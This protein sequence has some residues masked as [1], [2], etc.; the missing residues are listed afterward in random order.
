MAI[1]IARITNNLNY[2]FTMPGPSFIG[3]QSSNLVI[4]ANAVDLD[5]LTLTTD[6]GLWSIQPQ[7]EA[8]ERTGQVTVTG[9]IDTASFDYDGVSTIHADNNPAVRGNIRLVSGTNITLSQ[10]GQNITINSS[11]GGGGGS[12]SAPNNSIQFNNSG[13]FGG[14]SDLTWDGTDLAALNIATSSLHFDTGD[15]NIITTAGGINIFSDVGSSILLK[16]G[17]LAGIE[18]DNNVVGLGRPMFFDT[19]NTAA[20]NA[21]GNH[22]GWMIY[23][24][25]TNKPEFNNGS[26]WAAMTGGGS[27]SPAGSNTWIQYNDSGV[28]G[29]DGNFNWDK[30]GQTLSITGTAGSG[31]GFRGEAVAITSDVYISNGNLW[32]FGGPGDGNI[33]MENGGNILLN[34]TSGLD[35]ASYMTFSGGAIN[36]IVF[37]GTFFRVDAAGN[38]SNS[39]SLR[40]QAIGAPALSSAAEGSIY[41][42]SVLNK[43]MASE[44][45]GAYV[46]LVGSGGGSMVEASV[47]VNGSSTGVP[48]TT[49]FTPSVS[50]S[51]RIASYAVVTQSGATD[52][53]QAFLSWTDTSGVQSQNLSSNMDGSAGGGNLPLDP[54]GSTY[55]AEALIYAVA[56][57]PISYQIN[58]LNNGSGAGLYT[59]Y[60]TLESVSVGGG[61]GGSPSAPS[62]SVQYNNAGAFGSTAEISVLSAQ[63]GG[64]TMLVG[65]DPTTIVP[66]GIVTWLDFI[67]NNNGQSS[68][69]IV[70]TDLQIYS[71]AR[72]NDLGSTGVAQLGLNYWSGGSALTAATLTVY[73]PADWSGV[74]ITQLR[75]QADIFLCPAS[76]QVPNQSSV[77]IGDSAGQRVGDQTAILDI[78]ST[79]Q[80]FLPPRMTQAQRNIITVAANGITYVENFAPLTGATFTINGVV[81]TEGVEWTASTDNLTTATSLSAAI[82]TATATTLCTAVAGF[83]AGFGSV[84]ITANT[85]GPAGNSITTVS[86]DNVNLVPSGPTLAQGKLPAPALIVFN[87][88]TNQ[89]EFYN[90]TTWVAMTGGG[91]SNSVITV[92]TNSIAGADNIIQVD[93]TSGALII[94]LPVASS[95]LNAEYTIKKIDASANAV[96]IQG[97]GADTIDGSNTQLLNVQWASR[98][99]VCNGASWI[100]I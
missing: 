15:M 91:S 36:S 3:Q 57:Q 60:F 96:T 69:A 23:N 18:I 89:P 75:S 77:L 61:G 16:A 81:L 52:Q 92:T 93:A 100:L 82:T 41:F 31:P 79:E 98:T 27:G 46:P 24:T 55:S 99:V 4:P 97:N 76:G 1:I 64:K 50:G 35:N 42:D 78:Q 2:S 28:F 54:I 85:P 90:G 58:Y 6:D 71:S 44:N 26:V 56:G 10:V 51:Y 33:K 22:P 73:S 45:G 49:L 21:F 34:G 13:S 43:F 63:P 47:S 83:I 66:G 7:L 65:V 88:D 68:S 11:G 67:Q 14:S 25:D 29:A 95:S 30:I 32:F 5:L 84:T 48:L 40:Q 74:G 72:P 59:Y 17:P 87:T 70:A 80:G 20:R 37:G 53:A 86:S 94:T 9:T 19:V 12:P 8:L 38:I 39:A 62:L